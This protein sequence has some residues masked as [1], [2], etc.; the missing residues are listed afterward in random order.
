M[1][2][3]AQAAAVTDPQLAALSDVQRMALA[4]VL[5]PR[6]DRLV[7]FRGENP[8]QKHLVFQ[9][10]LHFS[11]SHMWC[12]N[13]SVTDLLRESRVVPTPTR[14]PPLTYRGLTVTL[15][16]DHWGYSSAPV[17]WGSCWDC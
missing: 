13:K 1:F 11:S 9:G 10:H 2:S 3:Y 5:T 17:L 7:D 15:Q 16:G 12:V 14:S 6:E 8:F 4:M